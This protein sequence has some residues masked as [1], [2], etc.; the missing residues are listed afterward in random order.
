MLKSKVKKLPDKSGYF[1]EEHMQFIKLKMLQK[2]NKQQQ[3]Y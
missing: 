2:L 3:C 1:E